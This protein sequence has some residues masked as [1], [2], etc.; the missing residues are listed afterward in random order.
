MHLIL[1]HLCIFWFLYLSALVNVC[2]FGMFLS[3]FGGSMHWS[4]D[5]GVSW[6][7][8][9]VK[10]IYYPLFFAG[11]LLLPWAGSIWIGVQLL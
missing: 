4:F 5:L 10:L 1:P 7:V 8:F 11:N 6:C 3:L 9:N 2:S